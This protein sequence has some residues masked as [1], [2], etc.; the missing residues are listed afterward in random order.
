[1]L[2][3]TEEAISAALLVRSVEPTRYARQ[4]PTRAVLLVTHNIEEAVLM[5]DRILVLA[6]NPGRIAAEVP[7]PLPQP[8]DRLDAAFQAI[9][10][11]IYSILTSRMTEAIG[12]QAQIHGGLVQRLPSASINRIAGFLKKR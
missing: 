2:R 1:M 8:R 4:L 7:V 10:N 12:A 11:E 5:C 3:S 6:S 9:V